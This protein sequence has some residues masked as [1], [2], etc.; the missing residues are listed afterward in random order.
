MSPSLLYLK[1]LRNSS[2][3]LHVIYKWKKKTNLLC[4]LNNVFQYSKIRTRKRNAKKGIKTEKIWNPALF[5]I[6]NPLSWNPESTGWNP[7]SKTVMDSLTW[8][9]LLATIL[10]LDNVGAF[11]SLTMTRKPTH[12]THINAII[13]R[14][15]VLH[16]FEKTFATVHWVRLD[17]ACHSFSTKVKGFLLQNFH[18]LGIRES[19]LLHIL[20]PIPSSLR[21]CL[22]KN[23]P[24]NLA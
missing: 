11:F 1:P 4:I 19:C 12:Q 17:L 14:H 15:D 6:R 3:F 2:T 23:R 16:P 22:S 5:G 9:D 8:A 10:S 18:I 13:N 7:E 24:L 20:P 21:G